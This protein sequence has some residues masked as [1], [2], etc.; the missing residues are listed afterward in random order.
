MSENLRTSLL[1]LIALGKERGFLTRGELS[2]QLPDCDETSG[3]IDRTLAMVADLGIEVVDRAPAEAPAWLT[4]DAAPSA[5]E[6]DVAE[7][8]AAAITQSDGRLTRTTDPTQMYLREIGAIPLL[9]RGEEVAITRRIEDALAEMMAAMVACPVV[10]SELLAMADRVACD[11]MAFDDLVDHIV[12]PQAEAGGSLQ[13]EAQVQTETELEGDD[14]GLDDG[15]PVPM[16]SSDSE[17]LRWRGIAF[18]RFAAI[19]CQ[20]NALA[21]VACCPKAEPTQYVRVLITLQTEL[22]AFRFS[23]PA[24]AEL[25][26][27][28]EALIGEVRQTECHIAEILIDK[29][30][31][32][33]EVF[34]EGFRDQAA[35]LDWMKAL[36]AENPAIRAHLTRWAPEVRALQQQL[37]ALEARAGMPL[38]DLRETAK[39]VAK[40]KTKALQARSEMIGANLRLV[41]SIAKKY[42]NRGLP[43]PDLIQEGNIG[44]MRAV[45]KFDYR[46]GY[47]FSTYATWWV[48]QAVI[49]AIADKAP[50]IRIPMHLVEAMGKINRHSR[51]IFRE[52]GAMPTPSML[53]ARLAMSEKQIKSILN[54]VKQPISLETPLGESGDALLGDTLADED[55]VSPVDAA[56]QV[57]LHQE[58]ETV[59]ARLT[60]REAKI[61]RMRFGVGL[62]TDY[63][64]D[65]I[66]AQFGLTRERIRQLESQA[67]RKLRKPE[68]TTRL[69]GFVERKT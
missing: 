59:L 6:E 26:Q 13:S 49:R 44:L 42:Q 31:I 27:I 19:R 10:V 41:V 40:A 47:K 67:L 5:N 43:L 14:T 32:A 51:E 60:P 20:A 4:Q 68:L 62:Q 21:S 66:G 1:A 63:T 46:R 58:M 17:S 22:A 38:G 39:R 16:P 61:L 56:T 2:D 36:A 54:L 7:E 37:R 48:R 69:N 55:T 8:V 25:T 50:S 33:R 64:L 52:T 15:D 65:E 30:G 12:E 18:E 34:L 24:I 11:E 35:N 45:D 28:L 29:C 57:A 3:A 9:T 53:A 23:P